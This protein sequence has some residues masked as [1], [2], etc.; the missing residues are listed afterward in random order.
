MTSSNDHVYREFSASLRILGE[1][2]DFD[3]ISGQLGLAPTHSHR[4]GDRRVATAAPF[5]HDGWIFKVPV[6]RERPLEEHLLELW[7]LLKPHAT[8]LKTLKRSCTVDVFCG[9]RSNSDTAGFSVA[10]S[11][12]TIFTELD[13]PFGVSVIIA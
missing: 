8:Y 5:E 1:D 4:R 9:Y 12:L 2:L 7:R 6:A 3:A 10:P 11:A 13:V